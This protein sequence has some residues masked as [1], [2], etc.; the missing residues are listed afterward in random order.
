MYSPYTDYLDSM[1]ISRSE[2]YTVVAQIARKKKK[3]L[4]EDTRCFVAGSACCPSRAQ[5]SFSVPL[6][7]YWKSFSA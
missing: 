2:N 5:L 1:V 4:L 7:S 6:F 3:K